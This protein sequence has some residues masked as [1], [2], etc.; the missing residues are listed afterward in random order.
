[1]A[2]AGRKQSG[3]PDDDPDYVSGTVT[4]WAK[5]GLNDWTETPAILYFST[6][7]TIQWGELICSALATPPGNSRFFVC[8]FPWSQR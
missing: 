5:T 7:E 3:R 4:A 2:N 6:V 1:M 8:T